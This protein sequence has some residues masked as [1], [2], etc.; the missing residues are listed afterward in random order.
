[1][2]KDRLAASIGLALSAITL[3]AAGNEPVS[4]VT[5]TQVGNE[6][7]ESFRSYAARCVGYECHGEFPVAFAAGNCIVKAKS[8]FNEFSKRVYFEFSIKECDHTAP[9]GYPFA[10]DSGA[11]DTQK[12]DA[13]RSLSAVIGLQFGSM[14]NDLVQRPYKLTYIRVDAAFPVLGQR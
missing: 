10:L 6:V 14:L 8:T 12:I 4:R 5:Y 13:D 1:M 11:T 7:A 2:R 3:S 9:N